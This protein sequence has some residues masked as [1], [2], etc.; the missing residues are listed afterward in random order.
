MAAPSV[1]RR[2][3]GLA[4]P[5]EN[6]ESNDEDQPDAR[7]RGDHAPP[8]GV[9]G[10]SSIDLSVP[11]RAEGGKA[12]PEVS[13]F[14]RRQ[15]H[16]VLAQLQRLGTNRTWAAEKPATR[17]VLLN[18]Y[19]TSTWGPPEDTLAAVRPVKAW[20]QA[21]T[22]LSWFLSPPGRGSEGSSVVLKRRAPRMRGS[23]DEARMREI[24]YALLLAA[25]LPWMRYLT[26]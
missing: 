18:D 22:A 24:D 14:S 6:R 21:M 3:W 4:P 19:A 25:F 2:R 16:V 26:H 23:S 10:G 8:G 12:T 9:P 7:D 20:Q 15:L 5:R 17:E 13:R 11:Y 1:G